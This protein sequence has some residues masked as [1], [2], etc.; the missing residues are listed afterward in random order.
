L[1]KWNNLEKAEYILLGLVH[2]LL[3]G[4]SEPAERWLARS[5]GPV[6]GSAGSHWKLKLSSANPLK[7]R[8]KSSFIRRV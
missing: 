8:Q 1:F 2:P 5:V 4:G 3:S 7:K 6:A